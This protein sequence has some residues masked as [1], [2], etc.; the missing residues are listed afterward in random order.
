MNI[1]M[2]EDQIKRMLDCVPCGD[3]SSNVFSSTTIRYYGNVVLRDSYKGTILFIQCS[4]CG[5]SKT[6]KTGRDG[7]LFCSDCG[8]PV[9]ARPGE[10][11]RDL[12]Q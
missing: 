4:Y 6:P 2:S 10:I 3:I 7:S 5:T 9:D 1:L 12:M 11:P 8:A